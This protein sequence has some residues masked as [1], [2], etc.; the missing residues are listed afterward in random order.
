MLRVRLTSSLSSK[1]RQ[2]LLRGSSFL[3]FQAY[4]YARCA[5]VSTKVPVSDPK[6]VPCLS[7]PERFPSASL[8][9]LR[10]ASEAEVAR[11]GG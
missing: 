1:D 7:R 5:G 2:S 10:H 9:H 11:C 3:Y 8:T 4:C 6:A